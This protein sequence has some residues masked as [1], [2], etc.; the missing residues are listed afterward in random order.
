MYLGEKEP[1]D[2]EPY[3]DSFTKEHPHYYHPHHSTPIYTASKPWN[4]TPLPLHHSNPLPKR[5]YTP[6]LVTPSDK[7]GYDF[8]GKNKIDQSIDQSINHT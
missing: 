4:Y 8:Q 3:L 2:K 5:D 7:L 1:E 6:K